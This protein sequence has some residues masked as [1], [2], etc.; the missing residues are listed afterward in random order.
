ML[1]LFIGRRPI[2]TELSS[3]GHGNKET[4]KFISEEE[5]EAQKKTHG[6][7]KVIEDY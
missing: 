6:M 1:R 7:D 5:I 4:D 2:R 3:T